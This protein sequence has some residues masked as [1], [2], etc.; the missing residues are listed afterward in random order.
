MADAVN[1][2]FEALCSLC[3]DEHRPAKKVGE[4]W[5]HNNG[6]VN[7]FPVDRKLGRQMREAGIM[8]YRDRR[9]G[10]ALEIPGVSNVP[11]PE[12]LYGYCWSHG[13]GTVAASDV[14]RKRGRMVVNFKLTPRAG[15]GT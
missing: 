11:I 15:T 2:V 6:R 14:L 7:W 8:A 5:R 4:V 13:Q 1:P 10:Q 3:A 12:R 9:G